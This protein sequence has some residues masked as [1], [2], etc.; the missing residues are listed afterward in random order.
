MFQLF[1]KFQ[2]RHTLADAV[3]HPEELL[4]GYAELIGARLRAYCRFFAMNAS[5]CA[6]CA[7]TCSIAYWWY[8]ALSL[9][10]M[11]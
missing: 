4:D 2:R 11:S 5:M 10:Q 1:L 7:T 9:Y 3:A 6:F 8:A